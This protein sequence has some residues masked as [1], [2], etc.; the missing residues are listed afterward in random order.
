MKTILPGRL[1]PHALFVAFLLASSA[2]GAADTPLWQEYV[3]AR[4]SGGEALLPDF[5]YAGYAHGEAPIPQ[6]AGP[7]FKVRDYGAIPDDERADFEAIQKAVDAAGAAGGGVVLF[8]KGVYLINVDSESATNTRIFLGKSGVVLRG[9]GDGPDGTV[10]YSPAEMQPTNPN[11]M[12]TGRCPVVASGLKFGSRKA[13]VIAAAPMNSFRLTV[14]KAGVFKVGDRIR[15]SLTRK[16]E[17]AAPF[18]APHEWSPKWT[19]G[20][21]IREF[22]EIAAV[23]GDRLVLAE[24]LMIAVDDKGDWSVQEMNFISNVG[25]EGLRFRGNWKEKFVHHRSWRDDSAWRGIVMTGVENA[26][27]R[28]CTFEDM[29]WALYVTSSRQVTCQ[30]LRIVGTPAHFGMQVMGTYGVLGV[31]VR[32]EAGHHH[33][34]SLQSGS[35]ATVYHQCVWSPHESFDSHANNAYATLHDRSEGGLNLKGVGGA[36]NNFP[37]HLHALVL[38]NLK[39][40]ETCAKPADFWSFGKQGYGV[41]FAQVILAGLHGEPQEVVAESIFRNESPGEEVAP[42]SL[43]LAQL[44]ERL[45]KIPPYFQD[46]AK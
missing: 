37:H 38:W 2:L 44:R 32:D 10:L 46:L 13:K 8:E 23:E 18:V 30:D 35:C 42:R 33:G 3:K 31:R 12:W 43:W 25:F 7:I 4:K 39:V 21:G 34:P 40:S 41:T 17:A 45:G 22:H 24:P 26:W 36:E 11:E 27:V 16:G 6:A 20:I 29:C 1:H 14:D 5:S 28:S 19:S 15:L 9:A